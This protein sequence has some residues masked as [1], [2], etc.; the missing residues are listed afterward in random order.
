LM[1]ETRIGLEVNEWLNLQG[2]IE[3]IRWAEEHG[4]DNACIPEVTD[5]EVFVTCALA[6]AATSQIRLGTDIVPIG[7]RSLPILA[8]SVATVASCAPGR[9]AVGLGVSTE[10]LISR[11]HGISWD[12]PLTRAR[13]TVLAL[14]RALAGERTDETGPQVRTRG[15]QLAF[16]PATPP[17]IHLAALNKGMLRV[18]GQVAD[19][20]WLNYV[21]A[22]RIGTVVDIVRAGAGEAERPMPEILLSVLCDVTDDTVSARAGIRSHL[23]FYMAAPPYRAALAWHGFEQE[24]ADA[25][26]AFERRDRQGV[27]AAITDELIDSIALVGNRSYVHERL[28]AY[29]AAGVTSLS[30]CAADRSRADSSLRAVAPKPD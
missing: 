17:P 7:P 1:V 25:Q 16:P 26:A 10:A 15:Y 27:A 3:L 11:W 20:V 24:M 13:D 6:L 4:F 12:Q 29:L 14:R 18:A 9:F 19:G 30:V 5:P 28:E 2:R 23:A 21:P 22:H 8:S